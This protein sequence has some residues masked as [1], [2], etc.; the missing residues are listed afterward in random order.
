ML[1]TMLLLAI[2]SL[3]AY[4]AIWLGLPLPYML[5][6]L[7]ASTTLSLTAKRW[8]PETFPILGGLRFVFIAVIGVLIGTQITPELL[9]EAHHLAWSAMAIGLFVLLSIAYNFSIFRHIGGYDTPTALY[10]GMPGGLYESIAMGD[11]A[12]ADPARLMLQQFLRVIVVVTMVPIGLSLW[13]GEAVGTAGGMTLAKPDVPW[14]IL[15]V[16]LG[17][18]FAGI[19]LGHL[20]RLPAG[21]LIGPMAV[22]AA[23][24]LT[25]MTQID[26]PQWLINLSLIVIGTALGTRFRALSRRQVAQGVGLSALSVGGMLM[27]AGVIAFVLGRATEQ[28][29]DVMFVSFAPGGVTEMTLVALSLSGNPAIVTLHHITR[30][31]LTVLVMA[32]LARKMRRPL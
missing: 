31:L 3:A 4:A 29:F 10:A 1:A 21:Q 11:E 7:L 25:G 6:P 8:M 18:I 5:G 15:P 12:G 13:L 16:T 2:C 23:L 20:L 24:S 17:A 9:A 27:L 32:G 30:I 26:I 28:D 22:G 14:S 19:A